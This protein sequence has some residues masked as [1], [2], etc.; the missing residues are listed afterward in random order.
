MAYTAAVGDNVAM[1]FGAGP[2]RVWLAARGTVISTSANISTVM[3]ID[4]AGNL[5]Q[6]PNVPTNVG[7]TQYIFKLG[8]PASPAYFM[9]QRVTVNSSSGCPQYIAKLN[10]FSTGTAFLR[11]YV[12][13]DQ[14]TLSSDGVTFLS[15]Y[16][17]QDLTD[18]RLYLVFEGQ[19]SSVA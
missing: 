5:T 1:L 3:A 18:G 12:I 8:P 14:L 13:V 2:G 4:Q 7:G 15:H 16:T 19:L 11:Q 9:G 10:S 17:L 6:W